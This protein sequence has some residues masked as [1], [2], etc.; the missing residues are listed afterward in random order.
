MGN[1]GLLFVKFREKVNK[2]HFY[3]SFQYCVEDIKKYNQIKENY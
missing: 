2:A 3:S 1:A